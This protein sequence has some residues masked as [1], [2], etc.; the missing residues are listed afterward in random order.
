MIYGITFALS[1]IL[2]IVYVFIWH[3]HFDVHFTLVFT[4]IPITEMGLFLTAMS[5]SLDAA[6]LG[7]KI[8]YLGSCF[9][10]LFLTLSIFHLCKVK[11]S[12]FFRAALLIL[13]IGVYS[14]VLTIGYFPFFYKSVSLE[15]HNGIAFLTNKEYAFGHTVFYIYVIIAMLI[16]TGTIVY[17]Y[18]RKKDVSRKLLGLLLLPEIIT[19][20]AYFISKII[21]GNFEWISVA[22]VLAQFAYLLIVFRVCLYN[23]DDSVI[24]SLIQTGD[25]AYI[26]IDFKMRYLGCNETARN[27]F[28][29]IRQ[30]TVDQ[31]VYEFPQLN[32]TLS[33]WV[34]EFNKHKSSTQ[35]YYE[36]GEKIYNVTVRSLYAGGIISGYQFFFTDD[37]QNQNYI[38]LLDNYNSELEKEVETKTSTLIEMHN[39]LILGMAAMVESRDNSTGGHIMRTS[40]GVRI[41]IEEIKKEGS[42]NLSDKFCNDIIKAAPMHDLGKVAVDDV[43]LR[44]PGKFTPEEY[45]IMKTHAAEGAKI[46]HKILE[47][48]EDLEFH[49]LAENVAHYHHER[50]DG[51]GYPMGLKGEEIPLEAR[52]MAIADVYD[53]LVSKR[54]YKEKMSFEEADSIIM[55]SFGKHFDDNL[56]KYYVAAKPKLEAYYTANES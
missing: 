40:E 31:P 34:N 17:R 49:L 55:D 16:G 20:F 23:I 32:E 3:K 9:C 2:T 29:E 50:W 41:L 39:K 42:L 8:T 56:K 35:F 19:I 4:F 26:S 27:I 25:T 54:V 14:L 51:S 52:I 43:I 28:P 21:P 12:K 7:L 37:T 53:A 45:E 46:V 36:S 24:D 44:K 22:Y 6:V 5:E 13:A 47:G 33:K 30:L 18:I 38:K 10:I 48:T 15:Y 11:I 1:M